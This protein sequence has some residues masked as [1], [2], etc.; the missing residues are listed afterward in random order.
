MPLVCPFE[1]REE[2]RLVCICLECTQ[3]YLFSVF[4]WTDLGVPVIGLRLRVTW[5]TKFWRNLQPYKK[6]KLGWS[7]WFFRGDTEAW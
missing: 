3:L 2:A 6:D 5:R 1:S 4:P 7:G